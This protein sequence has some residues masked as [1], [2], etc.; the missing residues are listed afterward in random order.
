MVTSTP[1]DTS[2]PHDGP[3]PPPR[4]VSGR[5]F[6][7]GGLA[8]VIALGAFIAGSVIGW[9]RVNVPPALTEVDGR[10]ALSYE[11][12]RA[13]PDQANELLELLEV[14]VAIREVAATPD[15]VGDI[16]LVR[17]EAPPGEGFVV[18]D[19]QPWLVA[20]CSTCERWAEDP[21][22]FVAGL[23]VPADAVDSLVLVGREAD[24]GEGPILE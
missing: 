16:E 8:V 11:Q 17:R 22:L 10:V 2:A 23:L 4:E 20:E 7:V 19:I 1:A 14:D 13:D 5:A 9:K 24:P 21:S 15:R 12:L 6:V 3:P 18:L